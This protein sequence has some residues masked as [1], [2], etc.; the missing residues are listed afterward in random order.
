MADCVCLE[1]RS[2]S[3]DRGFESYLFRPFLPLSPYSFP[4]PICFFSF[5]RTSLIN[6]IVSLYISCNILRFYAVSIF[7]AVISLTISSCYADTQEKFIPVEHAELYCKTL[8]TGN[9]L[10]VLHGGAGY[11]TH[12]YL[13]PHLEC[14]SEVNFVVFYD[15]RSL[16]KSIGELSPYQN[17]LKIYIDDI[18]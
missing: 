4:Y 9:P 10:I 6:P 7:F 2:P 18:E 13:L 15:L 1:N 14:F 11:L 12:D 8:R 17:I 3:R 5:L 16:R